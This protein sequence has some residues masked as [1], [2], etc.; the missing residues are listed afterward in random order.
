MHSKQLNFFLAPEDIHEINQFFLEKRCMI[1]K[2]SSSDNN[3]YSEYNLVMNLDGVYQVCL[4]TKTFI[5]NIYYDEA[6]PNDY[7]I[8]ILKSNCIE[9]SLGGFYPYSNKE[10]HA[11]RFYFVSEYYK[12]DILV[13]KNE[14]FINWASLLLKDFK[15]KLLKKSKDY[16]GVYFSKRCLKWIIEKKAQK[17]VDGSKFILL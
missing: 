11:S 9:F 4:T 15:V 6:K 12:D 2:R 14:Q 13:T 17:T 8:N 7:Y 1:L 16:P 3:F 5:K 10:L